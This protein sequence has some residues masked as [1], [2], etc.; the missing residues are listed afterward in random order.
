M[1]SKG[2]GRP[3]KVLFHFNVSDSL[4][5]WLEQQ[6]PPD[7]ELICCPE[8][9]LQG[10]EANWPGTH[11]LWHVLRP[12]TDAM[13][14]A[15]SA[16]ALIQKIGVGVNTI[17]LPSAARRGVA[18][19]NMPGV[20]SRA[21]AEMSLMLM[22]M[23]SRRASSLTQALRKGIWPIPEAIQ[24]RLFELGGKTVGLIGAG[25]VPAILGPWLSAMGAKVISHSR[26][27]KPSWPYPR[28][29]LE[30]LLSCSDVVSLHL[31]L[32]DETRNLLDRRR[33]S[34]MKPGAVLINTARGELID[35][36]A[37][38]EALETGR[39]SVAGLDVFASEPIDKNH[40]LLG[41]DNVICTPH[42]AWIT[43]DTFQRAVAVAI[44]NTRRI[45][46]GH[47]L[48]NSIAPAAST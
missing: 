29:S 4:R 48:L 21:V 30:E 12:V 10:F 35:E 20:N 14:Q 9:D 15:N 38:Y 3:L 16:L 24:E 7:W 26:H 44:E 47:A 40:R 5:Q 37:L 17:D 8:D 2:R 45:Q 22:L 36:E 27:P 19:C 46:A 42:M 13:M 41:H 11:V 18:V 43:Q 1:D 34:Q 33:L 28:L 25:H 23:A 6:T 32:T 31:P 39:I